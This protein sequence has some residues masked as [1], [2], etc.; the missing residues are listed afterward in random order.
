MFKN[1]Q[2]HAMRLV[3]LDMDQCW[4]EGTSDFRTD[5]TARRIQAI[6]CMQA[7]GYQL[8]LEQPNFSCRNVDYKNS[9]ICW[10]R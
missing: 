9:S 8:V 7:K 1:P 4:S 3:R 10:R 2:K 5:W 6:E